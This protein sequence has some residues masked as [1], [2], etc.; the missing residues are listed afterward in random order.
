MKNLIFIAPIAFL[1]ISFS[2]FADKTLVVK[3]YICPPPEEVIEQVN[4]NVT[5]FSDS[6]QLTYQISCTANKIPTLVWKEARIDNIQNMVA[7]IYQFE[8]KLDTCKLTAKGSAKP[9]FPFLWTLGKCGIES[10]AGEKRE[11]C[12]FTGEFLRG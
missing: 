10:K 2:V 11:V 6:L 12:I 3:N 7:C 1:S 8:N 9:K 4:M 5:K